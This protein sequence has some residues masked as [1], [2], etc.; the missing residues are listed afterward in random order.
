PACVCCSPPGTAAGASVGIAVVA[1]R[2]PRALARGRIFFFTASSR[3]TGC[4]TGAPSPK[5]RA[6]SSPCRCG[7][8]HLSLAPEEFD[9]NGAVRRGPDLLLAVER[10][11][12]VALK[13]AAQLAGPRQ[14]QIVPP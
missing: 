9:G 6:V 4:Y 13:T 3:S 12:E 1:A 2:A 10:K 14:I 7:C 5:K 8:D 11:L